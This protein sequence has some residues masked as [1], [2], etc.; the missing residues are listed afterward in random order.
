MSATGRPK[1]EFQSGAHEGL[2]DSPQPGWLQALRE[3]HLALAWSIAEWETT[4]RLTRRLRLL[5]RLAERVGEA[6]LDDGLPAPVR[7][8]LVAERRRS[9][10]RLRM[11]GWLLE[12]VGDALAGASY[13]R[14]L[15]KGAAYQAQ[16][17]P[18]AAGRLPSDADLL[19]PQ[20]ALADAEQRLAARGWVTKELDP[21]DQRYY[22]EWSHEIP[23]MR[24]PQFG[25]ELDLH[26]G[27]V[28]PVSRTRVDP[29]R[30]LERVQSSPLEGWSVLAPVDQV[31]H[32]AAHLFLDADLRDRVRDLVDL[33]GL[34]RHFAAHPRFWEDLVARADELGL[35]QPLALAFHYTTHW[36]G[37]PVPVDASA[38]LR[39][40]QL[41][42]LRRAW[43]LPLLDAALAP[44]GV[45][46]VPGTRQARAASLL[47]A[48]HHWHRMPLTLLLP[49][50]LHKATRRR[51]DDGDD[52]F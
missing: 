9:R 40:R 10:Y 6:G 2:P 8:H 50:L 11:L 47:L 12:R 42:P 30:L 25:L 35:Q 49:H 46:G 15:L 18:I 43:L 3:P 20:A 26:H 48:R 5:G 4:L 23:P 33:D 34:M 45:E 52:G 19:V 21:H 16:G 22:R 13:P 14:V 44:A 39:R 17:L 31:L 7:R 41:P 28:P 51:I 37:T 38:P 32:C 27:I 36:L 29:A 24:H 1:G